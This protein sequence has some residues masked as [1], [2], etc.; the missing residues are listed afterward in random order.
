[1]KTRFFF[2]WVAHCFAALFFFSMG[3]IVCAAPQ[4]KQLEKR[5]EQ[6]IGRY[7]PQDFNINVTDGGR[8]R[9]RGDVDALYDRIRVFDIVSQIVGV[10]EIENE[11]VVNSP[12]LPDKVVEAGIIE[13]LGI[14][15]VISAPGRIS[16]KVENGIAF[17][18]GEVSYYREKLVANSIA[19]WEQGVKGIKDQIKV[20]PHPAKAISDQLLDDILNDILQYQFP[21]EKGISLSVRD[22]VVTLEGTTR[23]LWTE[24]QIVKELSSIMGV[25]DVVSTL[26][27]NG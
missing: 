23:T 19:S 11:I 27:L 4:Q 20:A 12:I 14:A 17:L 10:K 8:V 22:G 3:Q 24:N 16:V 9:I 21:H 13:R 25:K 1:M 15:R 6:V 18:S 7:Y 26:K 2:P 5:V